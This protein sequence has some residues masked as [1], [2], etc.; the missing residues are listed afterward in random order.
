MD[1]LTAFRGAH[2]YRWRPGTSQSLKA[3]LSRVAP[4]A[5]PSV[6]PRKEVSLSMLRTSDIDDQCVEPTFRKWLGLSL[7]RCQKDL[8]VLLSRTVHGP[9]IVEQTWVGWECMGTGYVQ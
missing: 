9:F 1:S 8:S 5:L 3:A 6:C 2:L 4:Y 7:T